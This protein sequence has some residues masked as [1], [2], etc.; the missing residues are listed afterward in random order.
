MTQKHTHKHM[1]KA[2]ERKIYRQRHIYMHDTHR[3]IL[4]IY[5]TYMNKKI[6]PESKRVPLFWLLPLISINFLSYSSLQIEIK[7]NIVDI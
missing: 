4:N 2:R 6:R 1:Q 3:H 7:S 5:S